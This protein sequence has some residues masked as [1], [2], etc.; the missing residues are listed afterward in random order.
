MPE[1]N[2]EGNALNGERA[3]HKAHLKIYLKLSVVILLRSC[4]TIG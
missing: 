3:A 2:G 4:K 1:S